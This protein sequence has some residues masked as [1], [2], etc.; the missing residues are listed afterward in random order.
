MLSKF[1]LV[2]SLFKF[3]KLTQIRSYGSNYIQKYSV[4][5]EHLLE[6]EKQL[7]LLAILGGKPLWSNR[8]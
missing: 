5:A 8:H 2:P 3:I 4:N 7:S 1:L 6:N